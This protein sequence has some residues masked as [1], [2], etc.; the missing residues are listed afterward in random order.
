M[1]WKAPDGFVGI[2]V[3]VRGHPHRFLLPQAEYGEGRLAI[4]FIPSAPEAMQ[5]LIWRF[6]DPPDFG[7]MRCGLINGAT[8]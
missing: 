7:K 8:T 6:Q 3:V 4:R 2:E 1:T 5:M